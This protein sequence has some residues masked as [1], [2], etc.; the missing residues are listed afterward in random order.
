[1]CDGEQVRHPLPRA[2]FRSH[3]AFE[4]AEKT[5]SQF[6]EL[7]GIG[8]SKFQVSRGALDPR[9]TYEIAKKLSIPDLIVS[10]TYVTSLIGVAERCV[11]RKLWKST[12]IRAVT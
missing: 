7:F 1:M 8:F 12:A 11:V 5:F 4:S 6:V 3:K 10:I 2:G 9:Q